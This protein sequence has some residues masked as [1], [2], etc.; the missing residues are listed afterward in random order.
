[1]TTARIESVARYSAARIYADQLDDDAD[2]AD[3]CVLL[4]RN[5]S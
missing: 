4:Q 2:V 5:D 1:M 3:D